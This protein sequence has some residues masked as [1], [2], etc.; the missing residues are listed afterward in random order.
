MIA[1]GPYLWDWVRTL[2]RNITVA[3]PPAYDGG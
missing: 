2:I 1:R 3:R